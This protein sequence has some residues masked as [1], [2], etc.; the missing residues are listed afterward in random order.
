VYLTFR[1]PNE[2]KVVDRDTRVRITMPVG[3][4]TRL[5]RELGHVLSDD[6]IAAS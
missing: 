6:D 4:A 2:A 1:G 3:Q 5:W